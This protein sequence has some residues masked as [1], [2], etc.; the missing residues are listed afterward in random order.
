MLPG[1]SSKNKNVNRVV[2]NGGANGGKKHK[3]NKHNE[4]HDDM[5]ELLLQ[6]NLEKMT[7]DEYNKNPEKVV[8]DCLEFLLEPSVLNENKQAN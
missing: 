3:H 5:S 1:N 4:D 8:N 2:V 6:Y 7:E